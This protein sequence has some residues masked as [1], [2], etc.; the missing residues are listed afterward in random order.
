[1][2]SARPWREPSGNT[3]GQTQFANQTS[4]GAQSGGPGHLLASI[5]QAPQW[6]PESAKLVLRGIVHEY[7]GEQRDVIVEWIRSNR[8]LLRSL[9]D[10]IP[11]QGERVRLM[12]EFADL[13]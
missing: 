5:Q 6:D 4:Q 13:L 7:N 1:V 2:L 12:G 9:I 10:A 8:V 11:D 3:A